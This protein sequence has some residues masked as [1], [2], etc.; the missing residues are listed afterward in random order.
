MQ[1][2][3]RLCTIEDLDNLVAVS[4]ETYF[5]TFE[6]SNTTENMKE[7]LHTAYGKSALA[8]ELRNKDSLF[9]FAH[10]ANEVIGYLK[11]NT[12]QAQTDIKDN[13]A[14]ELE[15]LYI[16][17]EYLGKKVGQVLLEKAFEIA[18]NRKAKYMWL[19]VWE[20]N[21][22]AQRFYEKNGF[23]KFGEHP[24]MMGQDKQTDHLMKFEF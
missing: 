19:G 12:G 13:L 7:F 23:V 8:K 17:K 22:R 10:S 24:F 16:R 21:N 11:I 3:I 14:I 6:T 9:Y 18:K 4:R 20:H 5:E 2:E 15:R 1:I